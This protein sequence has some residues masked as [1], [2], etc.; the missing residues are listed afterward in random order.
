MH[1]SLHTLALL[2][3]A[4]LVGVALAD[5]VTGQWDF[6]DPND[7]LKATVGANGY[8]WVA[9]AVHGDPQSRTR[10]GTA[11]SFGIAPFPAGPD[12]VLMQFPQY[13]PL[14]GLELYPE[15]DAN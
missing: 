14:E 10:F 13:G 1:R 9:P 2:T 4:A 12:R 15:I 7:G 11:A 5:S 6:N 8:F 3:V